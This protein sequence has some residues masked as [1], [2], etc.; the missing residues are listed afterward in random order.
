MATLHLR[1]LAVFVDAP[2]PGCFHWVLIESKHDASVWEDIGASEQS[3]P[4]WHAAYAAGTVE[5]FKMIEDNNKG[6]LASGEDE[7]ASPV[8]AISSQ[9]S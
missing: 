8:G 4:N 2:D 3:F 7:N 9:P 1:R 5:L 6:P